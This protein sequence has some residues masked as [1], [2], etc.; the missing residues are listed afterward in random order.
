MI[1]YGKNVFTVTIEDDGK[2]FIANLN[3]N[4]YLNNNEI[5]PIVL[6]YTEANRTQLTKSSLNIESYTYNR[7]DTDDPN[8]A[9]RAIFGLSSSDE[10]IRNEPWTAGNTEYR[11]FL[12][13]LV[14]GRRKE[15]ST[16]YNKSIK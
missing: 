1:V 14:A 6:Y 2:G 9:Q 8:V 7:G 15:N 13:D 12:N 16:Q 4:V 5:Q 3:E 11:K 10:I